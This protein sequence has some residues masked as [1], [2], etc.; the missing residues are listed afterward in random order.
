MKY[1]AILTLITALFLYFP[2]NPSFGYVKSN[3]QAR[4]FWEE[5]VSINRYSGKT[6][7]L[8]EDGTLKKINEYA[9]NDENKFNLSEP[10]KNLVQIFYFISL[11]KRGRE[12][13]KD[14]LSVYDSDEIR[15][16]FIDH[17]E[18]M[19]DSGTLKF[20]KNTEFLFLAPIVVHE[21]RHTIDNDKDEYCLSPV[22]SVLML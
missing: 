7:K 2:V 1:G 5:Y 8:R 14:F 15:I 3:K 21:M 19:N 10:A 16:E 6:G 18:F 22:C 9:K 4:K 17:F 20:Y 12:I 11:S 13:L